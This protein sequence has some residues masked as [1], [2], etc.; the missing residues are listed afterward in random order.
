[1]GAHTLTLRQPINMALGIV[2]VSDAPQLLDTVVR[3]HDM[4]VL[5]FHSHARHRNVL[6]VNGPTLPAHYPNAHRSRRLDPGRHS[7]AGERY[8]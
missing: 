2:A 7:L 8:P 1:M 6:L 5:S 3:D 4:G